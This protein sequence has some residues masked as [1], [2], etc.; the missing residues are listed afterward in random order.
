MLAGYMGRVGLDGDIVVIQQRN[1]DTQRLPVTAISS[2]TVE[3][4][5]IDL[6]AICFVV[7]GGTSDHASATRRVRFLF[8]SN[9][10]P[11]FESFAAQVRVAVDHHSDS[12]PPP[13]GEA[14][15]G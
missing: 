5:D 6:M 13:G 12:R 3:R 1:R 9:S 10:T 11:A 7:D 4:L 15:H 14:L 8:W 2:V